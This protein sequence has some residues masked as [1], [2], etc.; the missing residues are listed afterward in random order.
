MRILSII[1][2]CLLAMLFFTSCDNNDTYTPMVASAQSRGMLVSCVNSSG[3]DLLSDEDYIEK[4]GIH[5]LLSGKELPFKIKKL[6]RN[7]VK[8]KYLSFKADLPETKEM[9]FNGTNSAKGTSIIDL[10]INGQD[11]RLV[12][13]FKYFCANKETLGGNSIAIESIRC[14]NKDI[15]RKDHEIGS[16]FV[17]HLIEDNNV[18]SLKD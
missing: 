8:K 10:K 6:E 5:G 2:Y 14:F 7:G 11:V 15:T 3:N 16:D 18:L 9:I 13:T 12:C 17:L 1:K 4:I